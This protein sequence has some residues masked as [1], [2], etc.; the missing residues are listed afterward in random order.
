MTEKKAIDLFN[1]LYGTDLKTR[2]DKL[3]EEMIELLDEIDIYNEKGTQIGFIKNKNDKNKRLI[4]EVSDV[5]AVLIHT[6]SILNLSID[7]L[8]RLA[9]DKCEKRQIN[10]NYKR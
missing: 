8:L 1:R 5:L 3:K 7:E 6:A 9:I 2:L 4:D 10:P